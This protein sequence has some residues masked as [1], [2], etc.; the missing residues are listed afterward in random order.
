MLRSYL[1]FE[2]KPE[3]G[4]L[5]ELS[6]EESHHL[7]RVRRARSGDM[8]QLLDGSG[9]VVEAIIEETGPRVC[10]LRSES[11]LEY[12]RPGW[13]LILWIGIPKG[14]GFNSILQKAAELGVHR[15]MPLL[16]ENCEV[17]FGRNQVPKKAARWEATLIEALKQ[18][19]NPFMPRCGM[20][21]RLSEALESTEF[22]VAD[23]L[24]VAAALTEDSVPFSDLK[25]EAGR[26]TRGI[27]LFIGPEGDFSPSEYTALREAGCRFLDLGETV[28]RVETAAVG[29]LALFKWG[30]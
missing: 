27:H 2:T 20:P 4:A 8:V 15:I 5:L 16:T 23:Y 21:H 13:D 1:P 14:K 12:S 9:T 25:K 6:E 22:K 7:L 24:P 28:L 17:S 26:N 29:A 3:E 18:S 30:L 19:G 10:R 11:V